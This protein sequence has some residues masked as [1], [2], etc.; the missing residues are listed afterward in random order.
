MYFFMPSKMINYVTRECCI[1]TNL[2]VLF[3]TTNTFLN[4]SYRN[5]KRKRK[6][7]KKQKT[8]VKGVILVVVLQ[9]VVFD[10]WMASMIWSLMVLGRL[11]PLY[12]P[13]ELLSK[14]MP[15]S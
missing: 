1:S 5:Q 15:P 2:K 10:H 11:P 14:F 9:G 13:L 12:S 7:D 4:C 3:T 8:K 6:I